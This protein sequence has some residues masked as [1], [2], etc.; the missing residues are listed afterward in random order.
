MVKKISFKILIFTMILAMVAACSKSNDNASS[1]NKGEGY[2]LTFWVYSDFVQGEQGE[3]MKKWVSDFKANNPDVKEINLIPK[4]DSELLTGL[5]AGV[6]LPDAFSA[7]ARDGKKYHQVIQLLDLSEMYDSDSEFTN[8][9]YPDAIDTITIDDSKWAVPFISYIPVIFRNLTVLEKAGINPD[10]GIPTLDEF[11]NQLKMVKD[12][13]IDAT[14]SWTAG[15]YF[16]PG[17]ILGA[18]EENLTVGVKDGKSTVKPEQ[19][20]RTFETVSK[21]ESHSN[22]MT[23][24]SDAALEAFKTD[25]LA[26]LLNGPWVEPGIISSGVKYDAQLVPPYTEG[27]RTGGLQG[28]DFIYGVDSGDAGKNDAIARWLKYIGQFE[29]MREWT[30]TTGRPMLRKDV[31]NDPEVMTTMMAKVS[32]EGLNGGMKQ[33]DF[34]KSSVMW[35]SPIGDF[36]TKVANGSLTPEEGAREF[37]DAV[38][39]LYAEAGE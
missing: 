18:D 16:A 34:F 25:Q 17:A 26:Y 35:P 30:M 3:L 36:A 15:G 27:G 11:V 6:G 8:G 32:S 10:E 19:V 20:A 29:Q 23:W 37:I 31:M 38:N 24:D 1:D 22:N 21:I 14:H 12:S 28:W 2:E 13:G 5:M 39:A 33:M 9:F 7:S 4:N